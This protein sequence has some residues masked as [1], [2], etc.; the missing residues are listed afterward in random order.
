MKIVKSSLLLAILVI[1]LVF[2]I[3]NGQPVE[4]RFF[5]FRTPQLPLFLLLLF[6]FGLGFVLASLW[7]SLKT[8]GRS[9][10]KGAGEVNSPSTATESSSTTGEGY[11]PQ[12]MTG[13]I[14]TPERTDNDG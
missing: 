14:E 4:L 3:Y 5:S 11:N 7:G 13:T 6:T 1:L 9:S 2:S 12:Q 8:I 10:K